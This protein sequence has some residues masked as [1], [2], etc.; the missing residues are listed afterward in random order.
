ML[1]KHI[2]LIG[3]TLCLSSSWG[4]AAAA[5]QGATKAVIS[6]SPKNLFK[7]ELF[8]TNLLPW[9]TEKRSGQVVDTK[10]PMAQGLHDLLNTARQK[11]ELAVYGIQEQE[12]AFSTLRRLAA[13]GVDIKAVVDQK[14]GDVGEWEEENFTYPQTA[15]LARILSPWEIVPD[16]NKNG[17]VRTSTIMHDKFVTVDGRYLWTGSSNLS[18]T[19]MGS[20]YNANVSILVDS[21]EVAEIFGEEFRSMHQEKLFGRDKAEGEGYNLKFSDG[22]D[23]SIYFSPQHDALHNGVIPLIEEA[24]K[25]LDIGMFYL[26]D[27]DVIDAIKDAA[28]RGVKVR[29]IYDAVAAAHPSSHHL[30]LRASGVEVRVENW[31]G[32]MHMKAAVVDRKHVVI[33]SMNW[34][35]AGNMSN[36]ENTLVIRKNPRLAAELSNYLD[37]LWSNLT[38]AS[39]VGDPR[40]ESPQSVNSCF[41]GI[42]NDHDGLV[43]SEETLCKAV[44]QQ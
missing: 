20:E 1:T 31:G 42:D 43:D 4:N 22:T 2:L 14:K 35:N 37:E 40:A 25:S 9:A 6:S 33:G 36:D 17:K 8:T 7:Y 39:I 16:Q 10:G 15:Q 12:W 13:K 27:A 18:H 34:T 44:S 32:K 5:K 29:L 3:A 23:L 21:P 19:C 30:D 28:Q 11:V 38:H 24:Q 26:T 41:D